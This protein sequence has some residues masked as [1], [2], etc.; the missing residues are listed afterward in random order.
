MSVSV[1]KSKR[2]GIT[3]LTDCSYSQPETNSLQ[4]LPQIHCGGSAHLPWQLRYLLQ[5]QAQTAEMLAQS[6]GA[7]QARSTKESRTTQTTQTTH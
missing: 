3:I 6:R 7:K 5:N 1:H 2:R 4:K